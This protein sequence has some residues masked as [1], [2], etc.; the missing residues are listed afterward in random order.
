[1]PRRRDDKPHWVQF[2][3]DHW[4]GGIDGLTTGAE[5]LYFRICRKI[6]S[7]G[8]P[9][10]LDQLLLISRGQ[11]DA[12]VFLNELVISKKVK[13][14]NGLIFC[15]RAKTAHKNSQDLLKKNQFRVKNAIKARRKQALT[16]GKQ[17]KKPVDRNVDRN[18]DRNDQRDVD[19]NDIRHVADTR[20]E[21]SK[22]E[23]KK[24]LLTPRLPNSNP[25]CIKH[26]A[27]SKNLVE[28][29]KADN[30]NNSHPAT[31]TPSLKSATYE[32]AH[33]EA[34]DYDIYFIEE[35]WISSGF[36]AKAKNPDTAFL[37]FVRKHVKG[38]PI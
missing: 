14:S 34:P 23:S 19:R 13:V 11:N 4:E 32:K 2:M 26:S 12:N 24:E 21:F 31:K 20:A 29:N 16:P 7:T 28:A 18:D 1:M 10:F 5:Y 15:K 9:V 6:W 30:V 27:N 25:P 38:N 3:P 33:E 35:K 36:A 37:G 17:K 22:K 8:K